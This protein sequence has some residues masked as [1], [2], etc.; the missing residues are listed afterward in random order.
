MTPSVQVVRPA[1]FVCPSESEN[2]DF[3][4]QKLLLI[5]INA[6]RKEHTMI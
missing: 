6:E 1:P 3:L 5:I 4:V 2:V